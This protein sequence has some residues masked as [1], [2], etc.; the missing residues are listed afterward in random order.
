[1]H[2]VKFP[3]FRVV[4]VIHKINLCWK[5]GCFGEEERRKENR[6]LDGRMAKMATAHFLVFVATEKVYRHRTPWA[7]YRDKLFLGV[8]GRGG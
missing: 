2:F 3:D 5:L 8:I 4:C 6:E 7:P 1:M